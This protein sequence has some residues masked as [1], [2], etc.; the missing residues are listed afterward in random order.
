ME[1]ERLTQRQK[2]TLCFTAGLSPAVALLPRQ[3]ALPCG[4]LA[5]LGLLALYTLA[6]W[7]LR[8]RRGPDPAGTLETG[9][10]G[11]IVLGAAGLWCVV[12]FARFCPLAAQRISGAAYGGQSPRFFLVLLAL[13]AGGLSLCRVR[14][15]GRLGELLFFPTAAGL[16]LTL[17]FAF[18]GGDWPAALAAPDAA[19]LGESVLRALPATLSLPVLLQLFSPTRE[20]PGPRRGLWWGTA[21]L[22]LSLSVILL[23][24]LL[25]FGP[26]GAASLPDPYITLLKSLRLFGAVER[27]E[28]VAVSVLV[29]GDVLLLA[30]LSMLSGELL[31]RALGRGRRQ[32]WSLAAAAAGLGL[33]LLPP[34]GDLPLL[35][36]SA[37]VCLLPL[38]PPRQRGRA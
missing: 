2:G 4:F 33:A 19:A 22:C 35:A 6:L 24:V 37:L 15:L 17:P 1:T 27:A 10:G 26:A 20:D 36:G 29:Y 14:T 21:L 28:A 9:A 18:S 13:T 8:L 11:R 16:L 30:A 32:Y 3:S 5:P 34:L 38:L 7:L 25:N 31:L 12:L 23:A